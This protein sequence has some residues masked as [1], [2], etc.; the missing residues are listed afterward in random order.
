MGKIESSCTGRG[1]QP[2]RARHGTGMTLSRHRAIHLSM[3]DNHFTEQLPCDV[4][5]PG[6]ANIIRTVCAVD[7]GFKVL[8]RHHTDHVLQIT[9]AANHNGLKTSEAE[10]HGHEFVTA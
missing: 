3:T 7:D 8:L 5:I 6:A 1:Q 2:A 9:A 4:V 10:E